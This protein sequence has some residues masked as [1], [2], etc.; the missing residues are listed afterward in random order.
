MMER[1][2]KRLTNIDITIDHGDI[3]MME[4]VEKV[5]NAL[6]IERRTGSDGDHVQGRDFQPVTVNRQVD[7]IDRLSLGASQRR[8]IKLEDVEIVGIEIA[9][10]GM[11]SAQGEET[12]RGIELIA[13]EE[14]LRGLLICIFHKSMYLCKNRRVLH[15]HDLNF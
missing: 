12:I 14:N 15:P 13:L 3:R 4:R 6:T 5:P 8:I 2:P 1:S 11:V 9:V 10:R 7:V